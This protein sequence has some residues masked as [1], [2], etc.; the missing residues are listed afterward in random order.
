MSDTPRTD[1]LRKRLREEPCGPKC[2]SHAH[3]EDCP[4]AN[5]EL[6]AAKECER[7]ERDLAK[8]KRDNVQIIQL[9]EQR[10]SQLETELA[11]ATALRDE[12]ADV[13]KNHWNGGIKYYQVL[14]KFDA[15]KE[16]LI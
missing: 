16:D 2:N 14:A 10:I 5:G 4:Y 13:L 11:E 6:V 7:L 9:H 3:D 8:A 1:A 15:L 12:L